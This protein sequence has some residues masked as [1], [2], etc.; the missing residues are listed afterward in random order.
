MFASILAALIAVA[1]AIP[2]LADLVKSAAEA[3][4]RHEQAA[5]EAEALKRKSE[6]DADVDA[7]VRGP[8]RVPDDARTAGQLA[9]ADGAAGRGSGSPSGAGV[10][11]GRPD[12]NQRT[13]S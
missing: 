9:A 7:W 8:V 11:P 6:K 10:V 12:D 4:N 3:W 2:V 5:N 1:R 13:G